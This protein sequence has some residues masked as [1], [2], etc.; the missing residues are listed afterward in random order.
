MKPLRFKHPM[1]GYILEIE[2]PVLWALILGPIFFAAKGVMKPLVVCVIAA[3]FTAGISILVQLIV[4]PLYARSIFRNH[5]LS[6]GWSEVADE[7]P[8]VPIQ[9]PLKSVVSAKDTSISLGEDG[10]PTYRL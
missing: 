5:F 1:N 9:A 2:S 8:V 6:R 4:L 7:S 3:F 10:I